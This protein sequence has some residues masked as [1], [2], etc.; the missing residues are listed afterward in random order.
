VIGEGTVDEFIARLVR[1]IFGLAL[2]PAAFGIAFAAAAFIAD[3][4]QELLHSPFTLGFVLAVV[5]AIALAL[6]VPLL[7]ILEHELG[8][9]AAAKAFGNE[10]VGVAAQ[11]TEQNGLVSASGVTVYRPPIGASLIVLAPYF[12]P[13]FTLPLLLVRPLISPPAQPIIDFLIGATLVWHFVTVFAELL[14]GQPDISEAT[15][16]F[17]FPVIIIANA[18]ITVFILAVVLEDLPALVPFAQE[19]WDASTAAYQAALGWLA[20]GFGMLR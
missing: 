14:Q 19:A 10:V 9:Y 20:E 4:A 6:R 3:S 12:L 13:L 1:C 16:L 7:Q 2:I 8:H 17:A 11:R 15:L 5:P 18:L